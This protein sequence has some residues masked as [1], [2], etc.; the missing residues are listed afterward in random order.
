MSRLV[1]SV[2]CHTQC[3]ILM[4]LLIREKA[5]ALHVYPGAAPVLE[6]DRALHRLQGVKLTPEGV[7]ELLHA[8]TDADNLSDFE[9]EGMV[10]F[11]FHFGDTAV[12]QVI[13]FREDGHARLEIRRM[14]GERQVV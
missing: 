1:K 13:A 5:E 14:E 2:L 9:S 6:V 3:Q 12:F 11:Y 7:D 10:S 4:Q 8:L